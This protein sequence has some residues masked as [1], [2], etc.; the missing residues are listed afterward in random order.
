MSNWSS[1]TKEKAQFENWRSFLNE[2]KFYAAGLTSDVMEDSLVN[3]LKDL[4]ELTDDQKE[5]IVAT[6]FKYAEQENVLLEAIGD[7]GKPTRTF[8][9]EATAALQDLLNSFALEQSALDKVERTINQWANTNQI[10]FTSAPTPKPVPAPKP[11]AKPKATRKPRARRAKAPT[12]KRAAKAKPAAEKKPELEPTPDAAEKKEPLDK[13]KILRDLEGRM[14]S[15][16]PRSSMKLELVPEKLRDVILKSVEKKLDAGEKEIS[17]SD[18]FT[19]LDPEVLDDTEKKR[20]N[21][22]DEKELE[23]LGN[24]QLGIISRILKKAGINV[25]ND[26]KDIDRGSLS[27]LQTLFGDQEAL[28]RVYSDSVARTISKKSV[29]AKGEEIK[30]AGATLTVTKGKPDE[31]RVAKPED[32]KEFEEAAEEAAKEVVPSK[33]TKDKI[34]KTST[35][36]KDLAPEEKEQVRK[37]IKTKDV[38]VLTDFETIDDVVKAVM[39]AYKEQEG[40]KGQQYKITEKDAKESVTKVLRSFLDPE[41]TKILK[42]LVDGEFK[43][44]GPIPTKKLVGIINNSLNISLDGEE[45]EVGDE[46]EIKVPNFMSRLDAIL[47]GGDDDDSSAGDDEEIPALEPA[48]QET[49]TVQDYINESHEDKFNKLLKAFVK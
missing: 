25:V 22:I 12:K 5:Q 2:N 7:S 28:R 39:D 48:L 27:I 41:D 43:Q 20:A 35:P 21:T 49:K 44:Y 1:F 32:T 9:A 46:E 6:L 34:E 45:E 18:I 23:E 17:M 30:V 4:G 15:A 31:V 13:N 3:F 24:T 47:A 10:K 33:E 8:S 40:I 19:G 37:S 16:L 14:K 36:V 29:R 11:P 38:T 26:R 42:T